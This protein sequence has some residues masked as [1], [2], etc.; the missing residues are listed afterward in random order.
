VQFASF[1]DRQKAEAFAKEVCGEVG[2]A[3]STQQP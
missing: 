1:S 2:E 3:Q